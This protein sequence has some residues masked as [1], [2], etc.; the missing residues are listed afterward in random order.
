[1]N[2]L[3]IGKENCNVCEEVKNYLE[4]KGIK[5][6]YNQIETLDETEQM[7]LKKQAVLNKIMSFPLIYSDGVMIT[8]QQ[9]KNQ[10]EKKITKRNGRIVLFEKERIVNAINHAMLE[11]NNGIDTELSNKIATE[12]SNE[13]TPFINVE[14]I[15]DLVEDKLLH[16]DRKD[17]A[18]RYILYRDKKTSERSKKKS[19]NKNELLS[20]EFISKYKHMKSPMTPLG[21]F[22][23]YRTY[24]RWLPEF[25][26]RE[27]WYE[28]VKRVV[29]YNC[30]LLPTSIEEAEKLFDNIFNLRQFPSGRSLWI[31]DTKSAEEFPLANFNCSF[32]VI[33]E[34]KKFGE[35]FHALLVGA[36]VGFRVLLDDVSKLPKIRTD[37]ELIHRAYNSISKKNRNENTS[38][39]F[40]KNKA[41]II[42]GD[43]KS[44]WTKALDF[45]F[46][47][48]VD[49]DYKYI[50]TIIVNYDNVRPLGEKLETFGGYA[51][52]HTS[53][54]NMMYKIFNVLKNRSVNNVA[55][56]RPIDCIDI[57]NI[58]AE[59]VVV[60][61][62]RRSAEIALIDPKDEESIKAKN[63]LYYQE[64]GKWIENKNILHRR[65]SNN[66]IVYDE[67]PTREQLHWNLEQMRYSGEP[68][69]ANLKEAKRRNP[70]AKGLNPCAS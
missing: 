16:S 14:E 35:L 43:S 41:E 22:V 37:V 39:V 55:K 31:A 7:E 32:V 68:A 45:L 13:I 62:V 48:L 59:N 20:D 9:L 64:N 46:D 58:I 3:I 51:S 47:L 70:N 21:E 10:L 67:K 4:N 61:G 53:I 65:M 27:Y 60:G 49:K 42:I 38:M 19:S 12:I 44:G 28:T 52:G 1:M 34:F 2:Y 17:V 6:I 11:T 40:N 8:Y 54:Q 24:S 63:N 33:D 30:R 57:S 69:F 5:F 66:T 23:Y 56:L 18:K 50:D 25:G 36:G 29:E 15:Q 26:R